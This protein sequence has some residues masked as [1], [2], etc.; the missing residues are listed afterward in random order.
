MIDSESSDSLREALLCSILDFTSPSGTDVQVDCATGW[1]SLKSECLQEGSTLKKYGIR[2]DLGRALNKNKNPIAKNAIKEFHKEWLR[3]NPRGGPLSRS[4][5]SQVVRNMN[6]RIRNRG[7]SAK[8]IAF[9]RDQYT[10]RFKL[11]NDT[12]LSHQQ[13]EERSKHHPDPV[14]KDEFRFE[15]GDNVY[16]KGDKSKYRA[17]EMSKITDL[18]TKE[19]EMWARLHKFDSQFRAKEY[20]MKLAELMPVAPKDEIIHERMPM[21]IGESIMHEQSDV[22]NSDT[23]KEES[24][25][26]EV[27]DIKPNIPELD[28]NLKQQRGE[29]DRPRRKAASRCQR[30]LRDLVD[31]QLLL[32]NMEEKGARKET[33][34]PLLHP[35]NWD[36]FVSHYEAYDEEVEVSYYDER[37]VNVNQEDDAM[38]QVDIERIQSMERMPTLVV[39]NTKFKE[40]SIGPIDTKKNLAWFSNLDALDYSNASGKDRN[41]VTE[42]IQTEDETSDSSSASIPTFRCSRPVI[43]ETVSLGDNV[44]VH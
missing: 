17:R 18:F 11:V 20:D 28:V 10:N 14:I 13:Y 42:H 44:P 21:R 25:T 7:L 22:V 36:D 4:E 39:T 8:E 24:D 26:L 43:P 19:K 33:R 30:K 32:V 12:D 2:I 38:K 37:Q 27:G 40:A 1:Q 15:I 29:Q 31:Q 34:S 35:W 5:I 3:L 41:D 6:S 9:Q 23:D 16:L